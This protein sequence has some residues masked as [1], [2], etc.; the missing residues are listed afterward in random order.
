MTCTGGP[1]S[2]AKTNYPCFFCIVL[3]AGHNVFDNFHIAGNGL[4]AFGWSLLH[5][6]T[7]PFFWHNEVLT[8]RLPA[9]TLDWA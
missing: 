6:Q 2:F 8:G 4:P 3:V 5:E 7:F 9:Y 1:D